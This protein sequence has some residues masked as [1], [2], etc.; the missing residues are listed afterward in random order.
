[1]HIFRGNKATDQNKFDN[2]KE[3]RHL[4]KTATE[5]VLIQLVIGDISC[6]TAINADVS[7]LQKLRKAITQ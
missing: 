6:Q 5:T 3:Y 2:Y 7:T 1:M 4:N